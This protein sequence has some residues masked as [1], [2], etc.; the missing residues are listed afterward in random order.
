MNHKYK[1]AIIVLTIALVLES[2]VILH[3]AG[4]R[5]KKAVRLLPPARG[6]IAIVLD[7]WG[8]NRNNLPLVE[9]INFPLTISI[10]PA[11]SYSRS[12]A[13]ELHKKGLEIILHL[14]MEPLEQS[15]L[16]K[17][18]ILTGYSEGEITDII[19][20]DLDN[21]A[22]AKGVS[23]HMGSRATEDPRVMGIIFRVLKNKH[24]YFLD[25]FV[26]G[27]SA[28]PALA[29]KISLGFAK[30]DVFLDNSAD[31]RY[32]RGQIYKLKN[33]A[34]AK[35]YAIGIGHDRRQT[36][37]VLKSEMPKLEREGYRFVFVSELV[38]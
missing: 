2:I 20:R 28:C 22:Y 11:L 19:A 23:N 8:Y 9:E 37:E 12:V 31:P 3:Q 34:R 27:R 15:P 17:N 7:D 14:P 26:S 10:L 1:I 4:R 29:R 18:T 21:I 6:R 5:P 16:E 32:I 24:L 35:G 36:L 13:E 33:L 25:S 30:R 38:K